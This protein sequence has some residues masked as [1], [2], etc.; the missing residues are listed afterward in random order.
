[1][2]MFSPHQVSP[3]YPTLPLR[4]RDELKAAV[5][6]AL[7]Q[8]PGQFGGHLIRQKWGADIDPQTALLVT[9]DY[10]YRGHEAQNGIHQGQVGS[11]RTLV[12]TLLSNYQTVGDGRFGETAFGL[13][14]PPDVGPAVRIVENVDEFADHGSGN[15]RTY[16]GIYRQTTPQAY[17]P[18]TQIKLRPA[19]FKKW[20]WELDLKDLYESYLQRSWPSDETIAASRPY[21]LRTS[22]KAAFVM[23]AWLQHQENSVSPKGLALAMR[24]AGL[25]ADQTWDALTMGQLQASTRL[26]AGVEGGR[27][28]LYRYTARDI[29]CY[30]DRSTGR[31]LL[32]IPGNSSPLHEFAN[33]GQLHQWIVEQGKTAATRQAVAAHFADED[34]EDGT[35]HA[36]VLTAL[37]GM[38]IYPRQYHLTKESGFFNNDG[39]WDPADYIDIDMTSSSTD[40]FAQ[41]VLSMKQ[42]AIASNQIIRDD[43]DVNR[44]NLSAIV[45]PIVQWVNQFGPLALFVPGG[46]GLLV[47][48]GMID[49]G[50]GLDQAVNG[51]TA[52]QRS[53]GVTRTVFG[54]LNA[55]PLIPAVG[56]LGKDGAQLA[57]LTELEHDSGGSSQPIEEHVAP[58]APLQPQV[59]MLTR[60][61]LLRGVGAPAGTFTDEVLAQIGKVSAVDNDMLRLMQAGRAPTPLLADIVDRFR[62]DQ[63]VTAL[64][65][66]STAPAEFNRRYQALQQ[67]EHPWVQ[68]F[69]RTYPDLPK[70]AVEQMF[71]RYGGDFKAAPD[72]ELA[73]ELFSQLDGKARHYQQH[74]R[75]NRAYEALYLRSVTSAESDTLALHSLVNLPGWPKGLRIEVLDGS[76]G[77]RVLDRAGP[78]DSPDGLRLIKVKELYQSASA[79]SATNFYGAVAQALSRDERSALQL[80]SEDPGAELKLQIS[81]HPLSRSG[82][83]TG[84]DRMNSGLAFEPQGLKGGGFPNTPVDE[85]FPQA[86]KRLYLRDVY[87]ELTDADADVELARMGG[88]YLDHI[89]R[90]K[91]QLQQLYADMNDWINRV[92]QDI[93]DMG[94]PLLNAGDPEAAGMNAAQLAAHNAALIQEVMTNEVNTRMELADEL[95]SV[96]RKRPPQPHSRYSGN[97]TVGFTMNLENENFHRLPGFNVRLND[98]VGLNMRNFQMNVI[99]SLDEFLEAFPNLQTLDLEDVDLRF[100]IANVL[101]DGELP[102]IIPELTRLTS[103]NLR[104]THLKLSERNAGKLDDLTNLQHLDMSD[105]PLGD[106]PLVMSLYQL[107]SLNLN[108]TG[109]KVCPTGIM[110]RP[111]LTLLDLGDNQITRVPP[112][113]L[114]QAIARDRV[115]L[116]G[117][118]ITDE[119][120]LQRLVTHR[121]QTGIN[122][123]RSVADANYGNPAVWL[124]GIADGP[125]NARLAIWQQLALRPSGARFLGIINT[126]TL[127]ADFRVNYLDFQTRVWRLLTEADASNELWGRLTQDVPLRDDPLAA[128]KTLEDRARLYAHWVTLGR[129]FPAVGDPT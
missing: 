27:L 41:L 111:Y 53:Q 110:D 84:L 123:W 67:S 38:A 85:A 30:R 10:D 17:G 77:G 16:E 64:G 54:V 45:E 71:D 103:L 32:Y 104:N 93:S 8:T 126:L 48:A 78:I 52:S 7:P 79:V 70:S 94:V 112:A 47:L 100:E 65:D 24:A 88:S 102:V 115:I 19:D 50:Y 3:P 81:E 1:M 109:I 11:S 34:R 74:V 15:H 58:P 66:P 55:L 23:T 2:T 101:Q 57:E 21:P 51:E 31:V 91:I 6:T 37:E 76:L 96:W 63:E 68:L 12:Q 69:Q 62:I 25:P 60:V 20:V 118:P 113:V 35:F 49:V 18:D 40:S 39:Y 4:M 128:F 86:M 90:L 72:P 5:D 97:H 106:P 33:S 114:S 105:N 9:L 14:T 43:A 89:A 87:P 26:S 83:A 99:S 120:T 119:D 82:L 127:T 36:G 13:Y 42:S 22:A 92:A 56:S 107:R 95:I 75:L 124:N 98:V 125:A 117:N 61:D 73:K 28:K 121:E 116:G 108:N 129:P 29:W 122:L 44:A 59:P 80:L 46:E